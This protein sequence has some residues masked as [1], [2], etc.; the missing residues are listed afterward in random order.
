MPS[1]FDSTSTDGE[2][3]LPS[4][5]K[6]IGYLL[7]N[8]SSSNGHHTFEEIAVRIARR[9]ISL[10]ILL[11]NGPVSAGGDQQRD[12]E[13]YFTRV[14]E[15]LPASTVANLSLSPIVVACTTQSSGLKAKISADIEGICAAGAEPVERIAI[16]SVVQIP[17]A[18]VHEIQRAS[19]D[20]FGVGVDVFSG[21]QIA[22]M[23]AEPDLFWIASHYL[24]IPNSMAPAPREEG[25]PEWYVAL[26]DRLRGAGGPEAMT[27]GILGEIVSGVRQ[28]TWD[29]ESNGDL[30]EWLGYVRPFLAEMNEDGTETEISFD[31]CY[32]ASVATLRGLGTLSGAEDLLRRAVHQGL[33]SEDVSEIADASTLLGYWGGAWSSGVANADAHEVSDAVTRMREHA[34]QVLDATDSTTYPLRAA[35]LLETLARLHF[36]PDW[37]AMQDAHGA[38]GPSATDGRAGTYFDSADVDTSGLTDVDEFDFEG[39]MRYLRRLVL[40]IPSA[41][42]F[43]VD[44]ISRLFQ[45]FAPALAKLDGYVEV[46]DAL[47]QAMA[48]LMG[49]NS[50]AER[51]RDRA[52]MF[53]RAGRPLEALDDLHEAKLA[54]FHGETLK[55]AVL[56]MRF[57]G[58]VYSDLGLMYAAKL[59]A[60][61]ALSTAIA[62]GQEDLKSLVPEALLDLMRYSQKSG[63]WLDSAAFGHTA[64]VAR[65]ALAANPFDYDNDEQFLNAEMNAFAALAY[66]RRYWPELATPY[67]DLFATTGWA[68]RI[69]DGADALVDAV[70]WSEEEFVQLANDQYANPLLHDVGPERTI[71]FAALGVRWSLTCSNRR[72]DVLATEGLCAA[73]QITLADIERENP[74]LLQSKIELSV[75]VASSSGREANVLEFNTSGSNVTGRIVISEGGDDYLQRAVEL[76]GLV[77]SIIDAAYARDSAQLMAMLERSMK[78]GLSNRVGFAHPYEKLTELLPEDHYTKLGVLVRPAV[79]G[80]FGPPT[81]EDLAASSAAGESYD[82]S[83]SLQLIESRYAAAWTKFRGTLE[84]M[85]ADARWHAHIATLRADGWLDWQILLATMNHVTNWR[86][87]DS[88][89]DPRSATRDELTS[90][91]EASEAD[92]APVPPLDILFREGAQLFLEMQVLSVAQT[93]G[94][95]PPEAGDPVGPLREL[96]ERRY[97]YADDDFPHPDILDLLA[98]DGHLRP[99]H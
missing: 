32:E 78:R 60:A 48:S 41:R 7:S 89:V 47:D 69:S 55:G 25:S 33:R 92:G 49:D 81:R 40:A 23:L 53:M 1:E 28:A 9:R 88:G 29:S 57:L 18:A 43:P 96:L 35:S 50:R 77:V 65:H 94:L 90:I 19:R 13:S 54:W 80:E 22:T 8:L 64:L 98:G 59:Y 52:M 12:A 61:A 38:P 5:E 56:V 6:F 66:L 46:R 51:L 67:L 91:V 79:I 24:D 84:A 10:N 4:T 39:A 30:P 95:R 82:S 75:E 17:A 37:G 11:A 68:D 16:F 63:A 87:A 45:M 14:P 20:R 76:I 36:V 74:D 99:L 44:S 93:W 26:L 71:E 31:A 3:S 58:K 85:A 83:E 42:A 2:A 70:T 27:L 73:L 72:R 15:E 34:E 97:R 21:S 86:L 62:K